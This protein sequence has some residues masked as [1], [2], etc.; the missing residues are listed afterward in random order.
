MA[1]MLQ[2]R[3]DFSEDDAVNYFVEALV[4]VK[5]HSEWEKEIWKRFACF[6]ELEN[7]FLILTPGIIQTPL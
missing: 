3:V 7:M 4:R 6:S 1:F 2:I 5:F